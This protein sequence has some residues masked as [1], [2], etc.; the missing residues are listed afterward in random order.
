MEKSNKKNV[1]KKFL[2]ENNITSYK[3]NDDLTVDVFED[4]DITTAIEE[5]LI[6]SFNEI[7]GDF[8]IQ[9]CRLK[10]LKGCPKIVNGDFNCS[11]NDLEDFTHGPLVVKG[12]Y[13]ASYSNVKSLK[14]LP[15]KIHGSLVLDNNQIESMEFISEEIEKSLHIT[16]NRLTSLENLPKIGI[17][18]KLTDNNIGSISIENIEKL[19]SSTILYLDFNHEQLSIDKLYNFLD[20]SDFTQKKFIKITVQELLSILLHNDLN[21]SIYNQRSQKVK[22]NNHKI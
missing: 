1:I 6:I 15:N 7:Q 10:T 21:N 3:I 22:S 19:N 4:V 18:A 17:A 14:G 11:I 8:N 16:K 5:L 12:N 20:T 9:N 13:Q 2:N